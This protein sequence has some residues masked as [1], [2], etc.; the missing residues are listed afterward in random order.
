MVG[1][2]F[3]CLCLSSNLFIYDDSKYFIGCI[4]IFINLVRIL[5]FFKLVDYRYRDILYFDLFGFLKFGVGERF[6]WL[7]FMRGDNEEVIFILYLSC[8]RYSG[9]LFI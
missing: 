9:E 7:V 2:Y 3:R 1:V 5:L 6:F 4:L 8:V